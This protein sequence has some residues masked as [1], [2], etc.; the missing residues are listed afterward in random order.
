MNSLFLPGKT[1]PALPTQ[2][3]PFIAPLNASGAPERFTFPFNYD[4]H[5][6][7]IE[8]S[9]QLQSYLEDM[10]D[11]FLDLG[12]GSSDQGLLQGKMFGVLVVKDRDGRLGQLWAYSG[13][14]T[15][16]N[17]HA[18]FVPL[19]FDIFEK[20]GHY[21]QENHRLEKL[22]EQ[23]NV[24]IQDKDYQA[25]RQKLKNLQSKHIHLLDELKEKH[26]TQKIQRRKQ[27]AQKK[28]ELSTDKYEK[29][30]EKQG[31]LS[32]QAKFMQKEYAIYLDEKIRN[33]RREVEV[34]DGQI[35]KL[36]KHRKQSSQKLQER[37]FTQYQL[38]NA[39]GESKSALDIFKNIPPYFPPSGTGDCAAPKLLQFAY[40]HGY[41]PLTMAEF[42]YGESPDSQVRQHGNFYPS[43]RSR[44]EPL[45]QHMLKGLE[46]DEN[47]LLQL[48]NNVSDLNIHYQDEHLVVIHKPADFLSVPG[49]N[50]T[51]S[52]LQ[53]LREKFPDATG[54]LL[55]HRLDM[56]TSGILV[57]GLSKEVHQDLQDQFIR[58]SVEKRYVAILNGIPDQDYGYIDLPLR[59]DLDNRP[60][61]LVDP[62][63]GKNA[64]TKFE[65][66]EKSDGRSR[67][68]FYPI[69]GRTHQLRVHAAH[70]DGLGC[71]IVGDDLY[72]ASSDRLYLHAESLRFRHPISGE[73]MS[74]EIPAEF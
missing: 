47:P 29:F 23:I 34:I 39:N 6:W 24:L 44:C 68:H 32:M 22:T 8:A 36:S 66:I 3:H 28:L 57:A 67:V 46:V 14:V 18:D 4:P 62:V 54:P 72:G 1:L 41:T 64:R 51:D 26:R 9:R 38:L 63:H 65:I 35:D 42:W 5:P 71:P 19:V 40:T 52:V 70:R 17:D 73:T 59:V 16:G 21:V 25:N 53:R 30:L 55:V 20:N 43:C 45:L 27:R 10:D 74:M 15:G 69:T 2:L 48:Q 13:V 49:K 12:L 7:A 58:R 33:L 37:V 50:I 56:G 61:Q 11:W 60:Y 31:Y